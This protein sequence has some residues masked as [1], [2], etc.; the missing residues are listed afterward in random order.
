MNTFINMFE[1]MANEGIVGWIMIAVFI[2]IVAVLFGLVYLLVYSFIDS[3][4]S[5]IVYF[6]DVVRE[7]HYNGATT[8]TGVGP[9][10]GG[11][12]GVAVTVSS[13]P[14]SYWIELDKNGGPFEVSKHS[15]SLAR[16]H[17]RVR[18]G[19]RI[20]GLS[21]Q[22]LWTWIAEKNEA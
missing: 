9:V 6:W 4:T 3:R 20:G 12:G 19:M 2:A 17:K 22:V 13:T 7:R 5:K 1:R 16:A 15:F 18:I 14:E 10:I 21:K 11:N 8:S